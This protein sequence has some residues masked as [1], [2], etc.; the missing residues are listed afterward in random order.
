MAKAQK[1]L[2]WVFQ[3]ENKDLVIKAFHAQINAIKQ[4]FDQFLPP[5]KVAQE[6]DAYLMG[7]L[8]GGM[9]MLLKTWVDNDM[10][11][12]PEQM[13]AL[14]FMLLYNGFSPLREK[15]SE[16]P[17]MLDQAIALLHRTV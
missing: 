15:H 4:F 17:D 14:T 12:S 13:A 10:R 3:V 1:L 9:F 2:R 7:F 5:L 6:Y 8:T 11:E 16:N